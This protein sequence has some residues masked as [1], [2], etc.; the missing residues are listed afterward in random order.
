[1]KSL[2]EFK[3]EIPFDLNVFECMKKIAVESLSGTEKNQHTQA[4][5]LFSTA[6]NKY[7]AI[8]KN[9]LSKERLD[10]KALLEKLKIANDTEIRY[11]LCMW[12]DNGIDIPSYNFREM[13][14]ELNPENKKSL[15]F[16]MTKDGVSLI[17]LS[18]TMK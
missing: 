8:I 15:I 9:A 18:A 2:F 14:C 5:V 12:Q 11:V 13:L 1:M 16:V 3:T 7:S 10:E 17:E 6:G 4:I